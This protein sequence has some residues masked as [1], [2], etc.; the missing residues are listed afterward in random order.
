M[1]VQI[2]AFSWVPKGARGLVKDLRVRWA[3]EESGI[4]YEEHLT[5]PRG[6]CP[7]EYRQWQPFGQ[8]PAYRDDRVEMF[9]SGAIVLHIARDN[10]VL[11]PPDRNGQARMESWVFAALSTIEPRLQGIFLIDDA[12][13]ATPEGAAFKTRM[14]E[15]LAN[16]L[17]VLSNCLGANE[18]LLG[19]IHRC[20]HHDG[21]RA[22]RCAGT[23]PAGALAGTDGLC[24][25]MRSPSG[26]CTG[27]GRADG[28]LR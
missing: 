15:L 18:Y 13:A 8:V 6:E 1:T 5:L 17:G 9:E 24:G 11:S 23:R 20:G 2:S 27:A 19:Q 14:S 10:P 22:A 7:D 21:N 26:I 12:L 16:R 4:A 28:Q 3:L 25:T